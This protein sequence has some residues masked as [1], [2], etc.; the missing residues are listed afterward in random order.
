ME[1]VKELVW[2]KRSGLDGV[3]DAESVLGFYRLDD[4]FQVQHS[5]GMR[6]VL[7]SW[8]SPFHS[9]GE[10]CTSLEAAQ[11][12]AQADYASRISSAIIDAPARESGELVVAMRDALAR[13]EGIANGRDSLDGFPRG[14]DEK[15]RRLAEIYDIA[16][17][18]RVATASTLPAEPAAHSL[19]G[20]E[21][22][23]VPKEPSPDMRAA[24]LKQAEKVNPGRSEDH[25]KSVALDA[26]GIYREMLAVV[27]APSVSEPVWKDVAYLMSIID[28][29]IEDGFD[30][31]E[32]GPLLDEIRA[33]I[34]AN[35]PTQP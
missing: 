8:R 3:W 23:M 31:D 13:I 6:L 9:A 27:P 32:D 2:V 25:I 5:A 35:N 33:S 15:Q 20:T 1:G 16:A 12:A 22:V 24:A 29:A 28:S 7:P 21:W 10:Q 17:T 14:R 18:L 30:P 34:T 4:A 19:Q 11:A 26:L